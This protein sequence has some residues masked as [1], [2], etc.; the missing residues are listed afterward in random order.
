MIDLITVGEYSGCMALCYMFGSIPTAY[1]V[2]KSVKGIDIREHGSG[3]PGATNVFRV[4]GKTAGMFTFIMDFLKGFLPVQ[5]VLWLFPGNLPLAS[6]SGFSA[7]A[8]H[9]WP[10]F[11][12][13]QGGKGVA[14]SA[15]VFFALVPIP[16][17]IA[18]G[19]FAGV[20]AATQ[21]VSVGSISGSL[22][23][24]IT[25]WFFTY[26]RLLT[27]LSLSCAVLIIFLHRKNIQR[28]LK[29][30]E[31]KISWSNNDNR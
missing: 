1:L 17:L 16:A 23:L 21:Y 12:K 20:F 15:G 4:V 24:P 31:H 3:N 19:I 18:I 22:S 29:G 10:V 2:A 25:T 11:L 6:L 26:S 28:L 13:F 30:E 5:I 14:T 9:N 8:G 27:L 7:I